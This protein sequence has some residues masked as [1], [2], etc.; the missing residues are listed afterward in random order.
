MP[1]QEIDVPSIIRS[2][3]STYETL[4]F[5]KKH[6]FYIHLFLKIPQDMF[7]YD[8]N[9]TVF[10]FLPA[11]EAAETFPRNKVYSIPWDLSWRATC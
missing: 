4:S 10:S 6:F 9:L 5:N 2:S 1:I 8:C 11:A 3:F 7:A